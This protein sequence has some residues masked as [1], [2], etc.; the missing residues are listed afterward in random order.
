MD[1]SALPDKRFKPK[2]EHAVF[3]LAQAIRNDLMDK[4]YFPETYDK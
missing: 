4:F 1:A 3:Y 2:I